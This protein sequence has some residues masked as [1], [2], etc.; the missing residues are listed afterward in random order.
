MRG[1]IKTKRHGIAAHRSF[2]ELAELAGNAG[3]AL[4]PWQGEGD[5]G[6]S[7]S[8]ARGQVADVTWQPKT[9]LTGTCERGHMF[10]GLPGHLVDS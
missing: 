7:S 10:R 2:S 5:S 6:L 3:I 9:V 8:G 1:R 4:S